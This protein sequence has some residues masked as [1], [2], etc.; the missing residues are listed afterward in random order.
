MSSYLTAAQQSQL[1]TPY[2]TLT[3]PQNDGTGHIYGAQLATDV[4]FGDLTHWLD[5]F[6]LEASGTLTRS[7]VYYAG[8]TQPVTVLGLAKWVQNYTLY[9]AYHGFEADV[10]LNSRT[11]A[12]A[13]IYGISETR[14]LDMQR[15]Q[16]WI[17]AQVSYSFSKGPLKGL[18]LIASG[19]NLGNEVQEE[20]QNND[21]RQVIRWEQYGR[22]LNV[23]FSYQFE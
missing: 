22:T 3:V 23:G 16:R 19:W 4:P 15:A 13:N 6:G 11:K 7:A 5:G 1:G 9:Y 20:Y 10:N 21:P 2:G 18:T 12:L 14:I 8:N 17:S